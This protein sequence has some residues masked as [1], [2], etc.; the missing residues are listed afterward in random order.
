ML[1]S[2]IRMGANS[3]EYRDASIKYQDRSKDMGHLI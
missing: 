3:A 2:S 1:V